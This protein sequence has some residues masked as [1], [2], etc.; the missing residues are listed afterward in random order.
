MKTNISRL[1]ALLACF[2]TTALPAQ[3]SRER[4]REREIERRAERL[5]R[6]IE[7]TVEASVETAMR[8][9]EK[10]LLHLDK[11]QQG[12]DSRQS[13]TRIDTTFAFSADGTVDLTSFNGDITVTGWN[14]KE[15]RVKASTERGTL[16][17]RFTSTR[18]SVE[19][20][21]Y[22]GRTGETT[23][24]V[25]VPEGARVVL[26]SMNGDLSVK[27]VKGSADVHTNNG[28]ID[29]TDA[30]GT[31]ELATL[32]G[33]VTGL[34]LR[35]DIDANSLNGTVL[36]TDVQGSSVKAESTSG[37]LELVNVVSPDIDASTVSGEVEFTGPLDPKGQYNFQSHSG[38]VTLTIP[39][40]TS[41]RF[42]VETFSGEV[43]SDFPFTLQPNRERRQGQRLEFTVGGGEAR[44]TAESFSGGIV[45]RKATTQRR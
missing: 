21:I 43:D 4:E 28:D 19:A 24:E 8:G 41:A 34:R 15:A 30:S 36:L 20:D 14:R 45:I 1:V 23:Y 32:S 13:A 44:V 2:V 7:R 25:T 38:A 33:D 29:V 42:S 31:I 6:N 5:S 16:R 17:W 18:I 9:V 39:P 10:A 37:S 12:Y 40:T 26:R 22:R 35:G 27:G 3:S 11:P